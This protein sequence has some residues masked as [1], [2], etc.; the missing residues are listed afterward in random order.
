MNQF[1][2]LEDAKQDFK[3]GI[4]LKERRARREAKARA[5]N[6]AAALRAATEK[7]QAPPEP[8][9]LFPPLKETKVAPE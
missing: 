7:A 9:S 3:L 8:E 6:E 1:V 4:R 5:A 2:A